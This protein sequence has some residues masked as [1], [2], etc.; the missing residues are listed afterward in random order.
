MRFTPLSLGPLPAN[1][2]SEALEI[3]VPD[4]AVH[5]SIPAQNHAY[6]EHG[7][8]FLACMPFLSQAIASPTYIGQSPRH[9]NQGFEIIYT[10]PTNE[11]AEGVMNVL[12]A[13]KIRLDNRGRYQLK[14]VY[15]IDD[16]K[17]LNRLETGHIREAK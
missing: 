15:P 16:L 7:R 14:S 12:I 6:R 11:T 4:G 2:V 13:V 9:R 5:F 3:T 8:D 10:A 1:L 17:I